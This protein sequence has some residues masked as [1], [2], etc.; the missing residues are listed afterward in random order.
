M[1]IF[2]AIYILPAVMLC[3]S[4]N[5]QSES[6]LSAITAGSETEKPAICE[7][8]RQVTR[9]VYLDDPFM[10][11]PVMLNATD[12]RAEEGGIILLSSMD[13]F[14]TVNPDLNGYSA[15]IS[16]QCIAYAKQLAESA[17][18]ITNSWDTNMQQSVISRPVSAHITARIFRL[19]GWY[20]S[21]YINTGF[22]E[23]TAA[24]D[25]ASMPVYSALNLLVTCDGN[26][27]VTDIVTETMP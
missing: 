15:Y 24:T 6:I 16:A 19:Y 8:R 22:F 21:T 5:A 18:A 20:T 7:T 11:W 2:K 27:Q 1:K 14:Y 3:I 12:Q 26:G 13:Y 17:C 25:P 9:D 4:S 23:E 10:T